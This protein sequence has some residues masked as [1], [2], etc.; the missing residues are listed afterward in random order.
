MLNPTIVTKSLKPVVK[1]VVEGQ[2]IVYR[3]MFFCQGKSLLMK[4]DIF[5]YLKHAVR[6]K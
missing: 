3:K 6:L 5:F 4:L 1:L 2:V